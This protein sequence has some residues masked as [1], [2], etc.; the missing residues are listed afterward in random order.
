MNGR[1]TTLRTSYYQP[2]IVT[3]YRLSDFYTIM[4]TVFLR[5]NRG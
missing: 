2:M 4:F 5:M 3:S 1:I